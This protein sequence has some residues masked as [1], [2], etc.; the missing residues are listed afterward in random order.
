M[1]E[2]SSPLVWQDGQPRSRLFG[3]IYYS[4]ED[5]LSET[6]A[7]FLQGCGLPEAWAGRRRFTVAEL[8]FG[9]GLNIAALLDL[10]SRARPPGVHLHIFSVEGYPLD[11]NET[12]AALGAWPRIGV[13]AKALLDHWPGRRRGFHRLD[14]PQFSATLD[15]AVMDV[16]PALTC[17]SGAADAWFLDGFSPALNP[18]MWREEILALVGARSAPGA[19]AATFTVAGAVRRGLAAAGFEVA[20]RPGH[21]R[22]RERLEAR[23]P[24]SPVEARDPR[25]LIIGG[26]IAGAGLARAFAALGA[27]AQVI[28]NRAQ[29][30]ASGNRAAL[31]APA[32]DAGGGPRAAFYAQALARATALY[33]ATPGAVIAR[34]ALQ[35]EA[36]PRDAARFDAVSRQD[37]FEPGAVSRLSPRETAERLGEAAAPGALSLDEARVV[38]PEKVLADWLPGATDG[39]VVSLLPYGGGWRAELADGA[40]VDGDVAVLAGG[41]GSAAL[42]ADLPLKPVRGQATFCP[43]GGTIVAAAS[44]AYAVPARGGVLFGATHDREDVAVEVRPGDDD[45]NR[46]ALA[47]LRPALAAR[48]ADQAAEGRAGIRATTPDRMPIAGEIAPGLFVLTGLGSRGFTTAPLLAEHVAALVL[49]APSPLPTDC[50][51]LISPARFGA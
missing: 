17:W 5:G 14:L 27:E 3:D 9:T 18:D 38:E 43:A 20:K 37:L 50:A 7:V 29:V 39:Q 23:M 25:V 28:R 42:S 8:G 16:A 1:T 47:G 35:M 45:R 48:L 19:A 34:G 11:R 2:A 41:W 24:G 33:D 51:G 6:E 49:G 12:A 21:G 13:A 26:G 31:V 44:G 32:L 46:A 10:W 30:M 22:K 4:L 36:A 15:L 40:T